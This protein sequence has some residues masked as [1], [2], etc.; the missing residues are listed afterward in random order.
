M[1]QYNKIDIYENNI[2]EYFER[3]SLFKSKY[4]YENISKEELLNK[5]YF[6]IDIKEM[7]NSQLHFKNNN[8]QIHKFYNKNSDK[9]IPNKN[10]NNYINY[11]H[12]IIMNS[13][14]N[15]NSNILLPIF[16]LFESDINDTNV[17]KF[18][19]I[20]LDIVNQNDILDSIKQYK[21]LF[22]KYVSNIEMISMK[23]K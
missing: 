4:K 18:Y 13:N 20:T 6:D 7:F 3:L 11:D 21:E 12:F 2:M 16:F 17:S 19:I 14:S 23:I 10:G 22:D 15:K 8:Y 5:F 1:I 9:I